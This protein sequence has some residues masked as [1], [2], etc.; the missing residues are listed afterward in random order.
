[1]I[2]SWYA[3]VF[4]SVNIV[5]RCIATQ[6][7]LL[8]HKTKI[9][10]RTEEKKIR[11]HTH[12]QHIYSVQH[13]NSYHYSQESCIVCYMCVLILFNSGYVGMPL[14]WQAAQLFFS[15]PLFCF[16]SCLLYVSFFD[17]CFAF[18][19]KSTFLREFLCMWTD[20]R[21]QDII[22]AND[23]EL[24]RS[25]HIAHKS[26]QKDVAGKS[27][28]STCTKQKRKKRKNTQ[29]NRI[30]RQRNGYI[31]LLLWSGIWI[32]ASG[33]HGAATGK[34]QKK[35]LCRSHNG[36]I[37][38]KTFNV[39][40]VIAKLIFSCNADA[41]GKLVEI[42]CLEYNI[43]FVVWLQPCFVNW[44]NGNYYKTSTLPCQRHTQ[45]TYFFDVWIIC[46]LIFC[47]KNSGICSEFRIKFGSIKCYR[48]K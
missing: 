35:L 32:A 11:W 14:V 27:T 26:W 23:S 22:M 10:A 7:Q 33:N 21:A 31:L 28:T 36:E 45:K 15:L 46:G 2:T 42:G 39:F 47:K 4:V 9:S 8:A 5:W 30:Q 1:M 44:G 19:S 37:D 40:I 43:H 17:C 18:V 41:N 12:T 24:G 48:K 13:I 6:Y 34:N 3:A 29:M 25:K 38:K 16:S 20:A